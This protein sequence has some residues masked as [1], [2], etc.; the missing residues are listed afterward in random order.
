MWLY[1]GRVEKEQDHYHSDNEEWEAETLWQGMSQQEQ[2][3][4][5]DDDQIPN[6]GQVSVV[7]FSLFTD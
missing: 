3:E 2:D 4:L 6:E 7:G 5:E 1:L